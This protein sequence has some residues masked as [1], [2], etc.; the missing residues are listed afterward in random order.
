MPK[1]M[2]TGLRTASS[3]GVVSSRCDAVVQI[4]MTREEFF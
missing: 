1:P 3:A 4:E 2:M